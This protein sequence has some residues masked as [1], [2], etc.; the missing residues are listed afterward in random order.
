SVITGAVNGQGLSGAYAQTIVN[1]SPLYTW[2]MPVYLGLDGNGDARYASGAQDQLLGSALPTF[3]A[4]LT[5][6]FTWKR[7]SASIFANS[8]RGFYIYN[9]TG[10]AL[11]LK[12]S[13]K[14]A[15]NVTYAVAN[16]AEDP[17]NPGSVSS[18]FL[19]KGDFIRLSNV[20]LSYSFAVKSTVIKSLSASLS[21]QNLLL[22]TNYSGLD[23]EVN[24]DHQLNGVPSRGFDYAGYPKARTFTIGLNIGF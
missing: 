5:N 23:P 21:G 3:T 16:S 2:K 14:T 19:E 24:V 11:F 17:I 10:N 7:W 8:V 15:H 1:G 12:G 13:L 18:R 20:S 4:G 22:I 6:S 9:N